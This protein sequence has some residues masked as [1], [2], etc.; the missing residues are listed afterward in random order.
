MCFWFV[1]GQIKKDNGIVDI[2]W[3]LGFVVTIIAFTFYHGNPRNFVILF[4]VAIWG[5]RLF[6]Y[7]FIRNWSNKED[8]RYAKWRKD[9]GKNAM[10]NAFFRVYM[11]QGIIMYTMC[12]GLIQQL[13]TSRN[14]FLFWVGMII[15]A[16]GL[17]WETIAD[18][19][20]YFFKKKAENRG[21]I[22]MTGLWKY[23]RHPNYFGEILTWWGISITLLAYGGDIFLSI[24]PAALITFF[25]VRVSGVPMLE[26]KLNNYPGY[27]DYLQNTNSLFPGVKKTNTN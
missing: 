6:F 26:K 25:I 21:R 13:S 22:L 17:I 15:W 4:L 1:L 12:L 7:L 20:L 24:L 10:R 16:V 8:W 9:W 27:K 5:I 14:L 2:S 23:S 18:Q 19:Q 3:G 11:L